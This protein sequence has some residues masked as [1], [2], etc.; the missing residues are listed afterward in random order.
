MLGQRDRLIPNIIK[1]ENMSVVLKAKYNLT[2]PYFSWRVILAA[3]RKIAPN[4]ITKDKFEKLSYNNGGVLSKKEIQ[5]VIRA[6]SNKGFPTRKE[7]EDELVEMGIPE[8]ELKFYQISKT[9]FLRVLD[10]LMYSEEIK[11]D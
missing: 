8:K 10:M 3:F 11:V 6:Y 2:V 4:I 7:V 9:Q 1:E 5:A